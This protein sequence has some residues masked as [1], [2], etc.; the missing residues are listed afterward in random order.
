MLGQ[1]LRAGQADAVRVQPALGTAGV[2]VQGGHQHH[3]VV[4]A[5]QLFVGA[6][7]DHGFERQGRVMFASRLAAADGTFHTLAG[8]AQAVVLA[9]KFIAKAARIT[10]RKP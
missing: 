5:W 2:A 4:Q 8:G 3:H 7:A 9:H 6:Q 1:T 10:L